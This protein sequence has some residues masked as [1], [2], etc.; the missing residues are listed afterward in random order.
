MNTLY[1]VSIV[2][3]RFAYRAGTSVVY[4]VAKK[5]TARER[6]RERERERDRHT[7]RERER[8]SQRETEKWK[9]GGVAGIRIPSR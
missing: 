6:E 8:D 2:G 9:G 3:S 5:R 1:N 7:Q 4:L